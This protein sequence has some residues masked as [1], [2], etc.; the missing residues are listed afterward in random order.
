MISQPDTTEQANAEAPVTPT[1]KLKKKVKKLRKK[2]AEF[3]ERYESTK[4]MLQMTSD[5][6]LSVQ[7]D[8]EDSRDVILKQNQALNDSINYA[9][10]I[11]MSML[12]SKDA[13]NNMLGK[14]FLLYKPKDVVSG[15]F[16]WVQE[17]DDYVIFGIIDCTGHGIPGAMLTILIGSIIDEVFQQEHFA[18]HP[19]GVLKYVDER[20]HKFTH[21]KNAMLHISD[22]L[23]MIMCS[24]HKPSSILRFASAHQPLYLFR[25]E[26][27][28]KFKGARYSLGAYSDMQS[29]I[30]NQTVKVQPEDRLYIF[31]DGYAD[32]FGGE[33]NS[34]FMIRNFQKLLHKVHLLPVEEQRNILLENHNNW[35]NNHSQ[36][37]D[38]IVLG[39]QF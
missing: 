13:R 5:H 14:H 37:D 35:K 19:A 25:D 4:S 6:L 17:I 23:D 9:Q 3:E 11:Q 21:R 2:V 22:G 31:S 32:Q 33:N 29:R 24:Y 30:V 36:T 12:A 38:V 1:K 15:D 18:I 7:A 10:R 39:V 26:K 8:L 34:K 27:L 28:I 16:Y 20:L